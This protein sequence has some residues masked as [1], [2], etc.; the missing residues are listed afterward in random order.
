MG[1]YAL[2]QPIPRSEDPRLLSGGGRYVDDTQ[3]TNTAH[4]SI[5]RSPFA[6][7]EIKSIDINKAKAA[8][9]VLLVLTGEDWIKSG[10]GD[11]PVASGRKRPDGTAMFVPPM[12][13]IVV[14]NRVRRVGDYVA[15]VV[16]ETENQA[17]D[18]CEM[19]AI[20]YE[21]LPSVTSGKAALL[22]GAPAVH[23]ACPDNICFQHE[24]GDKEAVETAFSNADHVVKKTLDI[25]R[26]MASTME[27][28]GCTGSYNSFDDSYTLYT[29]LQG[30]H[31]LSLIHI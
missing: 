20:D 29:T 24:V 6:H 27:P 13:P 19:I 10:W 8:P 4:A 16:A 28:R 14:D 30:V 2:G 9:G 7:A 11:L 21:V 26:V 15:M 31:P 18:A 12:K 22:D 25:T 3:L 23:D 1:E 5:L 17:K